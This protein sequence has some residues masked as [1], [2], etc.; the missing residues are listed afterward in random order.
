VSLV[1]GSDGK[2]AAGGPGAV[3]DALLA[4][5]RRRDADELVGLLNRHAAT[6][7]E[8]FQGW[9][10][11]PEEVRSDPEAVSSYARML[12]TV[13][14][15]F[16][17]AGHPELLEWLTRGG[18]EN[19][20]VRWQKALAQAQ[21]LNEASRYPES[22]ALLLRTLGEMRSSSGSAIDSLRPKVYGTLGANYFHLN[23]IE[24]ATRYTELALQDCVR[25]GDREGVR[26]YSANFQTL[27][28]ANPHSA[29]AKIRR[30]IT[31]AQG[32]SDALRHEESNAVLL[33]AL[34]ALGG[35]GP[36]QAYRP[37]LEGL[38]GTNYFRLGDL[39]KARE[40]TERAVEGCKQAGDD[41][42]VRIY[43]ENLRV[44]A[45]A[46]SGG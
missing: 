19:P 30:A 41:E 31:A 21:Q 40:H 1:D 18:E 5:V 45:D 22:N 35:E 34:G 26:T 28:S 16:Q 17:S 12:I 13:A 36:A 6:I 32:L 29:S 8:H 7:L 25:A 15:A 27:V 14:E 43:S 11:V 42:G 24:Q 23:D 37:K 33:E 46:A 4:A 2:G 3:R 20:V 9:T 39:H 38:L 10:K 44:I